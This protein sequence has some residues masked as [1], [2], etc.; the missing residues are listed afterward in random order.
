MGMGLGSITT[1]YEYPSSSR[2]M[3]RATIGRCLLESLADLQEHYRQIGIL[4]GSL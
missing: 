1:I 2:S 3:G 4:E